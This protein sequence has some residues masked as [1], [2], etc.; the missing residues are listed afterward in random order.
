MTK[1]KEN[2]TF[3]RK[4]RGQ[5][6]TTDYFSSNDLEE[7]E[8]PKRILALGERIVR[9]LEMTEG[10]DTLGKW[11][12]HHLASLIDEAKSSSDPHA[13]AS[14]EAVDLIFRIWEHRGSLP[15]TA[16][17][18]S[19]LKRAIDVLDRIGPNSSPFFRHS[20]N[21]AE[22]DLAKLFD[23]LRK[24]VAHGVLLIAEQKQFPKYTADTFENL[25]DE[26]QQLVSGLG[27]WISFLEQRKPT[28]PVLSVVYPED[29]E[30]KAEEAAL[31]ESLEP[32]ER[33]RVQFLQ[34]I[35]EL[36][37]DLESIKTSIGG[38]AELKP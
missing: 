11:M 33:S 38:T 4:Q 5:Q 37:K 9:E 10:V 24:L 21:R 16:D 27:G 35:D 20:E 3:L 6:P 36:I 29:Q 12:A 14:R 15:G 18:M 28:T 7:S 13:T 26:E 19:A 32:D 30:K 17:P 25:S 22:S 2:R 23:G 1:A 34:A 31:L 8:D